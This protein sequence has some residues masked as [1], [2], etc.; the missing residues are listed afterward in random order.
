[1]GLGASAWFFCLLGHFIFLFGFIGIFFGLHT[2]LGLPHCL[3]FNPLHLWLAFIIKIIFFYCF[4][5]GER[6]ASHD[7]I[8]DAFVSIMKD[9]IFHILHKQTHVFSFPTF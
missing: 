4:H 9:A 5:G 6:N 1:M 2:K 3:V 8:R 7:A